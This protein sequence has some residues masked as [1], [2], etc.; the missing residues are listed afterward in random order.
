MSQW[1]PVVSTC[2]LW[3]RVL[4]EDEGGYELGDDEWLP[5]TV[6]LLKTTKGYKLSPMCSLATDMNKPEAQHVVQ[7]EHLI[8]LIEIVVHDMCVA[9]AAEEEARQYFIPIWILRSYL[10]T[11]QCY[12]VMWCEPDR[13]CQTMFEVTLTKTPQDL[14][15]PDNTS[16]VASGYLIQDFYE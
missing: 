4:F 14:P 11:E 3:H 2:T 16:P 12:W 9:C 7:E 5:L 6:R 15:P 10:F 1:C 13:G 8:R